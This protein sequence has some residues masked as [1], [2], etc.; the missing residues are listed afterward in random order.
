M[1]GER[2]DWIWDDW[3][4]YL[5]LQYKMKKTCT[6]ID[7]KVLLEPT[8]DPFVD[9]GGYVLKALS[10]YYP[11]CDVLELIMLATKIYVDNWDAKINPF[12]LNSKIT[13]P[14]FKA[15]KK[16]EETKLYFLGLLEE[17]LPYIVGY[18]RVTGRKTKLF[19]AG[20]DNTVL[21]GS[22]TFVNFHNFFDTGIMLSKEALIRYHFLPLGCELLQGR[23][24]VISSTNQP[25]TELYAKECCDRILYD[26]GQNASLG[27]LRNESR[28]PGTAIFRFLDKVSMH[29]ADNNIGSEYITLYHFTNFGASPDV[30]IYTLPSQAFDFYKET[31]KAQYKT[32]WNIFVNHHYRCSD[33]KKIQYNDETNSFIA[34]DK[35]QEI[36]INED[37]FKFWR[38]IIYDKLLIGANIISDVRKWSVYHHF[39]LELLEC[40]LINIQSMKKETVD[41]INQIADFILSYNSEVDMKKVLTKLNGVK[42][43]YLLRRFVLKV[44]EDNYR[45]GNEMP[46]VTV[47]DYVDY[48]FPDSNSWMETRDVLLISIYQKLH[49]RHLN[50][51]AEETVFDEKEFVDDEV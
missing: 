27:L 2:G 29:Y 20:R 40:Y 28:S 7:Y 10:D 1:G 44:I 36:S 51:E 47:E 23:V 32:N 30:Q 3:S 25:T 38:N 12:F 45:R 37:N 13:Q 46:L 6:N 39:D 8:G 33:Y 11:E 19:P 31:R 42:N 48:L 21:S 34:L 18:C 24:C 50:V 9:S 41:K 17:T 16:K 43:P 4:I 26:L 49:E 35:K 5:N 14:A 15:E 22:G